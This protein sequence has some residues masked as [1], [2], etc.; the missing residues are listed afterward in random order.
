MSLEAR[1]EEVYRAICSWPVTVGA[2]P[3]AALP[4]GA[5]VDAALS[6]LQS[7]KRI[8]AWQRGESWAYT[9]S[10]QTLTQTQ[11]MVSDVLASS[12]PDLAELVCRDLEIARA[13]KEWL[14]GNK[15]RVQVSVMT[16]DNAY[17]D[18]GVATARHL[19]GVSRHVYNVPPLEVV[20]DVD[21][22][23]RVRER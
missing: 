18:G 10:A 3:R 11:Q 2:C 13:A 14:L 7:E 22:S 16:P 1:V 8:E 23:I 4:A 6:V 15:H 19:Q 20:Y 21:G 12:N 5:E 9:V 17:V